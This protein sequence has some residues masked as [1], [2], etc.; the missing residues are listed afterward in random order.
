MFAGS[1]ASGCDFFKYTAVNSEAGAD[2]SGA[3]SFYLVGPVSPFWQAG[4]EFGTLGAP[5]PW[6]QQKGRKGYLWVWS[7]I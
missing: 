4:C 2:I 6:E 7:R 5:G 1:A 3:K